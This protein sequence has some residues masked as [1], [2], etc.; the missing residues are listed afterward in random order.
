M[1]SAHAFLL[2]VVPLSLSLLVHRWLL[3]ADLLV[4]DLLTAFALVDMVLRIEILSCDALATRLDVLRRSFVVIT[5]LRVGSYH[6]DVSP[7]RW[8]PVRIYR[9]L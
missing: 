5:S 2:V 8:R 9:P 1:S 3:V 6:G 4:A 7:R